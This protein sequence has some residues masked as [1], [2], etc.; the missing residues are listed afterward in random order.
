MPAAVLLPVKAEFDA[1]ADIESHRPTTASTVTEV[2][3]NSF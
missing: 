3:T 2:D 1:S